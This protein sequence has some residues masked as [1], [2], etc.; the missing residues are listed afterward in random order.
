[1]SSTVKIQLLS[2]LHL[3]NP[4]SY[5]L[6]AVTPRAPVL[7]LIGDIGCTKDEG[8]FDFLTTQVEQFQ[9]VFFLLG[10]HEPYGSDW[11]KATTA[12]N[13]FAQEIKQL[14][15]DQP[16][17]GEFIFLNRTRYDLSDR[18][19]VLG[20]TLYSMVTKIEMDHVSFGLN[21]F[22]QIEDFS[23]EQHNEAHV[24]DLAWLNDQVEAIATEEPHRSVVILTHHSPT[25]DPRA[26]DPKHAG[27]NIQSGFSTD[28]SEETC[29]T[30]ECVKVWAFGHTH[31]N[32]DFED[33]PTRLRVVTNQHG[34]YFAQSVGFSGEKCFEV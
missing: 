5:D 31:F 6:F 22:Y 26:V 30:T 1:M 23:V 28:L 34:Y 14:R 7:A 29:W 16:R 32:C 33:E 18:V 3:E 15:A 27:G 21:D 17:L 25:R 24:A 19:T 8:L 12:V 10:N 13:K 9:L 4:K 20:C 2:D 11:D